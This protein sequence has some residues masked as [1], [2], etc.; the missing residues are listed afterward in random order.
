M[1]AIVFTSIS[2]RDYSGHYSNHHMNRDEFLLIIIVSK[3]V[4]LKEITHYRNKHNAWY[5]VVT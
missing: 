4:M 1:E 5:T 3:Q 2:R